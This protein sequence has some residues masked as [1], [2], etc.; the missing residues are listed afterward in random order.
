MK[1]NDF[2]LWLDTFLNFEK[3]Q[4]KN[5]F[6]LDTMQF[7]CKKLGN[8]ELK[9][10]CIHVAGSKGKGSTSNMIANII[11]ASGK[12]CGIYTSPHIL[13]FKERITKTDGFFE[14]KIYEDS[15]DELYNCITNIKQD[16]LPGN[17]KITWFELVTAYSFLCFKNAK[18]DYAVYEVGLGGRLDS[19]NVVNPLVS[20]L[21]NI[22]KEHTEFLGD[23]IEKIASEKAGIIKHNIPCIISFQKYP[24]AEKVFTEKAESENSKFIS[25]EKNTVKIESLKNQYKNNVSVT[26]DFNNKLENLNFDLKTLGNVQIQNAIASIFAVKTA[27]PEISNQ[28]ISEGL[29]NSFLKG[30]FQIVKNAEQIIVLD[31]AH[32]PRSI[33]NTIQTLKE[34]FPNQK[35]SLLFACASDKDVEKIIPQFKDIFED[36]ILTKPGNVRKTDLQKEENILKMYNISYSLEENCISAIRKSINYSEKNKTVLLITGSFYLLGEYFKQKI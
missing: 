7:L 1:I 24:E 31:G 27:I 22:E 8:P 23:T 10:P 14:D 36:I 30:R 28:Q 17:R 26:L 13:N 33:E 12:T 3:T 16:E 32:T 4:E 15:A 18:V 20:V 9:I 19:T 2:E 6:W 25:V 35:Y 11:S 29:A 5:I 21:T 34:T